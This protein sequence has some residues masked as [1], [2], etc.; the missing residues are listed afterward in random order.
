MSAEHA[1]EKAREAVRE[2]LASRI[3][4]EHQSDQG[5]G[6]LV[7]T[8]EDRPGGPGERPHD[9]SFLRHEWDTFEVDYE[10]AEIALQAVL[11][12]LDGDIKRVIELHPQ[13]REGMEDVA[14]VASDAAMEA[15]A[16]AIR[17][18]LL[19]QSL[20]LRESGRTSKKAVAKMRTAVAMA[21]GT[22]GMRAAFKAADA[23]FE[24]AFVAVSLTLR[25]PDPETAQRTLEALNAA[26][27]AV[28]DIALA[29]EEET[30]IFYIEAWND[31]RTEL[32]SGNEDETPRQPPTG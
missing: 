26:K 28:D 14:A 10:T 32:E 7:M 30:H 11:E 19:G 27:K 22:Y 2:L 16:G 12:I 1:G 18:A 8:R 20:L 6:V 4:E 21:A 9:F 24:A 31:S 17:A 29:V 15:G 3:L 13:V 5:D 25:G 23:M